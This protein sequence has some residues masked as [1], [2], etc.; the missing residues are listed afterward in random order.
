M[1]AVLYAKYPKERDRWKS[2]SRRE[3]DG[4]I[5]GKIMRFKGAD[6]I[7]V[8]YARNQCRILREHGSVASRSIRG[9]EILKQLSDC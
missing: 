7:N 6:W 1:H 4:E 3:N 9:E 2:R 5:D 8:A